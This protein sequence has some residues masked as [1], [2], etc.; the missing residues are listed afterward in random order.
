MQVA[1]KPPVQANG[2]ITGYSIAY[3]RVGD[4]TE[5][6]RRFLPSDSLKATLTDFESNSTYEMTVRAETSVGPGSE[7]RRRFTFGPGK[8]QKPPC[9]FRNVSAITKRL[10]SAGFPGPPV[11]VSAE[12]KGN[13]ISLKWNKPVHIV[14]SD[15]IAYKIEYSRKSES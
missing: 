9:P 2:Q 13:E 5:N 10:F 3:F 7:V 15:V 14:S 6:G 4:G 11:D 8:K 1:W 12:W